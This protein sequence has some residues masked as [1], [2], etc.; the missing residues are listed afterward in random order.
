VLRLA[1]AEEVQT[2]VRDRAGDLVDISV[3]RSGSVHWQY[4]ESGNGGWELV[5]A[6]ALALSNLL[7]HHLLWRRG[8]LIQAHLNDR[9]MWRQRFRS[10]DAAMAALPSV[11]AA[12]RERGSSQLRAGDVSD[13]G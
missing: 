9:R 5:L 11:L 7:S 8:W 6:P 12:V 2:Q 4:G 1:R 13:G 10:R 3:E